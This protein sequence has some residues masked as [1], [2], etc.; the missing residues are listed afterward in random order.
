MFNSVIFYLALLL[1]PT[2]LV[3][4]PSSI[5]L[6]PSTCIINTAPETTGSPQHHDHRVINNQSFSIAEA[7]ARDDRVTTRPYFEELEQ[8]LDA[9]LLQQPAVQDLIDYGYLWP[10]TSNNSS[11]SPAEQSIRP[12]EPKTLFFLFD[13]MSLMSSSLQTKPT[14]D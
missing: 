3:A 7:I 1:W 2:S 10:Y 14:D 13:G 8:V 9:P 5:H 4:K 11:L 6:H 12:A